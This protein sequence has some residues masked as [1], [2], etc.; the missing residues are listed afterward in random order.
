MMRSKRFIFKGTALIAVLFYFLLACAPAHAQTGQIVIVNNAT[1]KEAQGINI[2]L[3]KLQ[4]KAQKLLKNEMVIASEDCANGCGSVP[5]ALDV[6]P[7]DYK[8]QVFGGV[9]LDMDAVTFPVKTAD[10]FVFMVSNTKSTLSLSAQAPGLKVV[11]NKSPFRIDL[12]TYTKGA[13][14]NITP[15]QPQAA[16]PAKK[17]FWPFKPDNGP[18]SVN[19]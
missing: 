3:Y 8:I 19:E 13:S 2:Q 7:G 18:R 4:G 1:L 14:L 9:L 12:I 11:E 17:G 5:I 16:R 6:A 10:Q 15:A